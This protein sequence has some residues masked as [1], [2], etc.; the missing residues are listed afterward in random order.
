MLFPNIVHSLN[1]LIS[2]NQMIICSCRE[3]P[4][5]AQRQ[6]IGRQPLRHFFVLARGASTP[7]SLLGHR[8]HSNELCRRHR[9]RL[10]EILWFVHV[11]PLQGPAKLTRAAIR[12]NPSRILLWHR[13]HFSDCKRSGIVPSKLSTQPLSANTWSHINWPSWYFIWKDSPC[14]MQETTNTGVRA[15]ATTQTPPAVG[16]WPRFYSQWEL[17]H[18]HDGRYIHDEPPNL[19]PF[20]IDPAFLIFHA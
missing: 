14:R 6:G 20:T 19:R 9:A 8:D 16:S 11:N 3:R 1:D 13:L 10:Q 18:L 12:W 17:L 4:Y 5:L 2:R 15:I 7:I